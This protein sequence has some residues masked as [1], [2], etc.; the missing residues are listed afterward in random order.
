MLAIVLP[1][2][3]YVSDPDPPAVLST[4]GCRTETR[5][6]IQHVGPPGKSLPMPVT[7]QVR[8]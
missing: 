4:D 6:G 8:L 2:S 3:A 7:R 5:P 1:L